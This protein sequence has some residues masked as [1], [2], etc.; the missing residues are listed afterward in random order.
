VYRA[1]ET[2]EI[3][4]GSI[5]GKLGQ[6][7]RG[8]TELSIGGGPKSERPHRLYSCRRRGGRQNRGCRVRCKHV[9]S[10]RKDIESRGSD[11]RFCT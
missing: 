6:E 8:L 4:K 5:G 2:G 7:E 9:S 1:R 11:D 3:F 10:K